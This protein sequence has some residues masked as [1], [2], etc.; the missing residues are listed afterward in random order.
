MG[1]VYRAADTKLGR[2]VALKVLPAAMA[3]D[4][5]FL[6]RFQREARSVAALNHPNIVT[7]FSVEEA[8]GVHFLTMELVEGQSIK[9]LIAESRLSIEQILD[10]GAA[11]AEA[12]AAAHEKG[13]AHRD[14]KPANVMVTKD[15][16]VKVLDFG[17]AKD[18]FAANS[19]GATAT[20]AD[21]TQAGRVMGTPAYM[22]P[23]PVAGRA[24]RAPPRLLFL[25]LRVFSM[26]NP[27]PPLPR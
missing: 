8:E 26:C 14:L 12:L 6:G 15:G 23:D 16:R 13:I 17:L 22:S 3:R 2:D 18:T 11:L 20:S 24:G 9:Q 21:Y 19:A 10:L 7:M 27:P 5:E 1:E 4:P 25:G